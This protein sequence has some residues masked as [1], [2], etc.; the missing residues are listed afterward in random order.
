MKDPEVS[1]RLQNL[2]EDFDHAAQDWG[3]TSDQGSGSR[4]RT[5]ENN[6]TATRRALLH[7]IARLE[8]RA[9]GE[10]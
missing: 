8:A 4:V 10:K 3:W 2:V 6:Y 1:R 9:K 5:S 7:A